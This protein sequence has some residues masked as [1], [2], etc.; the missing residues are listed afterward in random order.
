M[1]KFC[2]AILM[3]IAVLPT[4]AQEQTDTIYNPIVN[5]TSQVARKYTIRGIEISGADNYEDYVLIGFSG[6]SLGQ[7][8]SVS[9]THLTLPTKA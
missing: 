9:Y 5:H 6:L 4:F 2:I 7:V 3:L 1:R 8:I